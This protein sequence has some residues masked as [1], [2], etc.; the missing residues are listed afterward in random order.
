MAR[1]FD[2]PAV[3]VQAGV[4]TELGPYN[5]PQSIRRAYIEID[6]ANWPAGTQVKLTLLK[7]YRGD[8]LLPFVI[9]TG[10]AGALKD[11]KLMAGVHRST[12][13]DAQ[14]QMQVGCRIESTHTFDLVGSV[15]A[16]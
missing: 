12:L 4:P 13:T 15:W 11:G 2:L 1:L 8:P 3:T 9:T 16:D 7:A 14:T 6:G 5:A 10:T